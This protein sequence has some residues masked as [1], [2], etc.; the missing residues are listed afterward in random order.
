MDGKEV[1]PVGLDT[2][3]QGRFTR[4]TSGDSAFPPL[5]TENL[6]PTVYRKRE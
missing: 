2:Y 6:Y 4:H 5:F 1:E 3:V